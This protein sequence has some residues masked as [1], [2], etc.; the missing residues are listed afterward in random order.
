MNTTLEKDLRKSKVL[1]IKDIKEPS[2]TPS[3]LEVLEE[4]GIDELSMI[5]NENT[6][7][8]SFPFDAYDRLLIQLPHNGFKAHFNHI[9]EGYKA[10]ITAF[11]EAKSKDGRRAP[12]YLVHRSFQ[13]KQVCAYIL[14]YD[15]QSGQISGRKAPM[16]LSEA[17]YN[18]YREQV[19]DS[20][21]YK[22]QLIGADI[23]KLSVT[24]KKSRTDVVYCHMP[25]GSIEA[26]WE[27]SPTLIDPISLWYYLT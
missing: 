16:G 4:K 9:Q 14:D 11:H 19:W 6:S 8:D 25:D 26:I 15:L 23:K 22:T 18:T 1:L 21:K 7:V 24:N 20:I 17:Q 5:S 2:Y 27:S 12:I 13:E 3:T 10:F